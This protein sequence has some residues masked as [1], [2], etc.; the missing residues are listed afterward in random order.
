VQGFEGDLVADG[1]EVL[2]I[3][4]AI[5]TPPRNSRSRGL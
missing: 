5:L 4:Q 2:D 1:F 3:D